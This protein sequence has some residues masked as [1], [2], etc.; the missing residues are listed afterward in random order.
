MLSIQ[1]F[2]SLPANQFVFCSNDFLYYQWQEDL[3]LDLFFYSKTIVKAPVVFKTY[4]PE[5]SFQHLCEDKVH[6][7]INIL[8]TKKWTA[9]PEIKQLFLFQE[10]Q[11]N[12]H[13]WFAPIV[14]Y[15]CDLPHNNFVPWLF[16]IFRTL[17]WALQYMTVAF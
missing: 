3:G 10:E 17:Q 4:Q 5:I 9:G 2:C 16:H 12:L 11:G 14:Y 1:P 13:A 7:Y 8:W 6:N 15:F